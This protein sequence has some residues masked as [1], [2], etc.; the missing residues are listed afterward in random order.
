MK[1]T[2]ELKRED[3]K[4]FSVRLWKWWRLRRIWWGRMFRFMFVRRL[5]I[6]PTQYRHSGE[7]FGQKKHRP[8]VMIFEWQRMPDGYRWL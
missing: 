1:Y 8:D 6:D 7:T 5:A 4:R 3:Q 2:V